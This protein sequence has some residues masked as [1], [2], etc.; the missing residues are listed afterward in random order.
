VRVAANTTELLMIYRLERLHG[1]WVI[2]VPPSSQSVVTWS[3]DS[4]SRFRFPIHALCA[5]LPRGIP[6]RGRPEHAGLKD[7]VPQ[8]VGPE[9]PSSTTMLRFGHQVAVRDR[10]K[11][12]GGYRRL[13][14][15]GVQIQMFASKTAVAY[16]ANAGD[17]DPQAFRATQ[18]RIP[19]SKR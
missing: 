9:I 14:D 11:G 1:A 8:T 3:F 10:K 13:L 17:G 15:R 2:V 4:R 5:E 7:V 12:A 16:F 6:R 18:H 19:Q